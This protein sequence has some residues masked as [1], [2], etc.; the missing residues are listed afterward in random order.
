MPSMLRHIL[1]NRHEYTFSPLLALLFGAL[2][3]LSPPGT[4]TGAVARAL[5]RIEAEKTTREA[6]RAAARTSSAARTVLLC[7]SA[8]VLLDEFA[9]WDLLYRAFGVDILPKSPLQKR[10]RKDRC[11]WRDGHPARVRDAFFALERERLDAIGAKYEEGEPIGTPLSDV[12]GRTTTPDTGL[13]DAADVRVFFIF[14]EGVTSKICMAFN[15]DSCVPDVLEKVDRTTR[16]ILTRQAEPRL[17]EGRLEM[18][19]K[20]ERVYRDR[21]EGNYLLQR[22]RNEDDGWAL[23]DGGSTLGDAWDR[24]GE[25]PC[26]N[27][28]DI[29]NEPRRNAC[30]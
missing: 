24:R 25:V 2:I 17:A 10:L 29:Q 1:R 11:R 6:A 15:V 14:E 5:D 9:G 12:E 28:Q 8:L 18:P 13:L 23:E 7:C 16:W 27:G 21:P 26:G 3:A 20:V 30:D 4:V 19:C 22:S